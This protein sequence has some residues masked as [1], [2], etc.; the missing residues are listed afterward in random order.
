[1][2]ALG[3]QCALYKNAFENKKARHILFVYSAA[4]AIDTKRLELKKRQEQQALLQIEERQLALLKNLNFKPFLLAVIA[5]S[6]EVIVDKPLDPTMVAFTTDAAKNNSL[7]ELVAR[8][9]PVV[10]AVLPLL[11]GLPRIEGFY[12]ELRTNDDYLANTKMQMDGM[13]VAT[14]QTQRMSDFAA[15]VASS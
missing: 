12:S 10:E 6:L 9:I 15:L 2:G 14:G 13:L 5:N 3:M 4:R 11:S 8:W 7:P 1:M